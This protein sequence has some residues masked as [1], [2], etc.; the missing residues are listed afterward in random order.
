MIAEIICVGTELLLGDILNTNAQYLS[1]RLADL[2][3][4]LYYQTVVGDNEERLLQTINHAKDRSDLIIL[5]GG[6]GPTSDD[7]TKETV[8]KA[9][10]LPLN[11]NNDQAEK[12]K[13]FFEGRNIPM[14]NNN[15]KQAFIPEGAIIL[16]N[17]NGTAPGIL[18]ESDEKAFVIL[19]GP[20]NELIPMFEESVLPYIRKQSKDCIVSKTLKLIGI[21]EGSA[22]ELVQSMIDEQTN[23]S[24][25]PYAK[26]AEVHFR[27][28]ARSSS[29]EQA[30]KLIHSTELE[31]R[32]LLDKYIY[33]TEEKELEEII[34]GMLTTYHKT[35]SIAE[36]CTGGLLAS[37]LVNCPGVSEVFK[38]GM[39]V[40]SNDSKI[41]ELGVN[42]DSIDI[43]G[44]VS[45]EVIKEMA[46]GIK[47]RAQ[48]D[49]GLAISGIA[50]PTGGSD[51]KPVGLVYIAIAYKDETFIKRFQ[52]SGNRMKIRMN[53][54]KQGL[55]FL[56]QVL[57]ALNDD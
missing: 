12:L 27:I 38:E 40:Y 10:N 46:I 8:A 24:I 43:Y 42:E 52:L 53:A 47:N 11:L 14:A 37:T 15:L 36:S 51:E 23:P 13:Q 20:P 9:L 56:Y 35:I 3:V 33:T 39:I 21:G 50:G 4:S 41:K 28:T 6:L 30:S 18:I 48:A 1:L 29:V 2:G 45:E 49:V 25:A 55:I 19:P 34:V 22:A 26:L 17:N 7:I 31:M 16:N 44:A 5:S 32:K 54:A 57:P